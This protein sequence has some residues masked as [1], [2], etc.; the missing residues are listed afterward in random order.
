MQ[1]E[2]KD[3]VGIYENAASVELCKKLIEYFELAHKNKITYSRQESEKIPK[4]LKDDL[5]TDLSFYVNYIDPDLHQQFNNLFWGTGYSEYKNEFGIL[6]EYGP[7]KI[8]TIKIQKTEPSG[9]YHVWHSEDQTLEVKQRLLTFILYL[10]DV[11]DGGET[12][13][14]YLSRR[15]KPKAGTLVIW[16]AG[17]THTHRG[18]PPLKGS[19][20]IVTGWVEL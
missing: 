9:G 18:N 17:F 3:F 5:A 14:L 12:E 1:F 13:F 7:H 2:H 15:I 19:K 11:E 10:N 20:Y 8:Y 6:N 16:P 4:T